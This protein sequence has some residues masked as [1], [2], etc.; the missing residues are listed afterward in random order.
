MARNKVIEKLLL[1][2]MSKIYGMVTATRN[3]LFNWGIIKQKQFNVP[4]VVVGNIAVGGSGKTPH[5]EYIIDA[6]KQSYRIGVLSRGYKRNTKGFILAS[7]R[8][9]PLDIGDEPYQIYQK[10]G[11]DVTV[12]V[13][14]DRC[15]GI[16]ELLRINPDINLMLLDDAFQHRY[17]KPSVSI[18]LT[19][20]NRPI[21]F[22]KMLPL[23]RLRESSKAIYRSDMVLVTK[24][25]STIKPVEYRIFK[26]HLSLYPYQKLY[27]SR[28][29][30]SNLQPVFPD[31]AN[32]G[33]PYLEY[34]S[35]QDRILIISG[36]ANPKPFVRYI[37]NFKP[38]VKI[39]T[40]PDHHNFSRK[41][42][43]TIESKFNSIKARNKYIITTEKDA[44]RMANNPYFP[45]TLRPY[46]FYLPVKVKF[47][48]NTDDMFV[49]DL[50]K[51]IEQSKV[52]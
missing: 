48:S 11:T 15:K 32:R 40:F 28:F 25:P 18:V 43:D 51:L 7:Q 35:E 45:P 24:C 16:E 19:E 26:N 39:L 38:L 42:L 6:L 13:C 44:V 14:E 20:F 52:K 46:V 9:T 41:D 2:P 31:N 30:Y 1:L 50:K 4:V 17:V 36:I 29:V 49:A 34:L 23:G 22:D 21:F 10:Y 27:F 3:S 33:I 47:D 8:S 37:K 12:A 5:V